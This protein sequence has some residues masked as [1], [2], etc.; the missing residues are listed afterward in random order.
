MEGIPILRA[1][2]EIRVP[3]GKNK[4][5][6]GNKFNIFYENQNQNLDVLLYVIIK[7]IVPLKAL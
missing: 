5:G 3:W 6:I 2:L 4:V 1:R 7:I